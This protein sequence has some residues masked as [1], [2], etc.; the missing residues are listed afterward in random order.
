VVDATYRALVKMYHP[1][2]LPEPERDGANATLAK[3]NV[4]YAQVTGGR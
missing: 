3:F 4:A 2:R 1:D